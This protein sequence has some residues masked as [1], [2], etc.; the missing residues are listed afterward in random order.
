LRFAKLALLLVPLVLAGCGSQPVPPP[1][2][3]ATPSVGPALGIDLPTDASDNLAELQG[4]RISFVARYYRDPASRWPPLSPTEAQRLSALGLK[5]VTVWEWHSSDPAYFTYATGYNDA[6]S[7]ERQA[8]TVG[9]PPGSAIYFAVDF[10]ARDSALYQVEQYFRGV[11]AG[12]AAAGGGRPEY[13]IGVYGSGAVCATLK[14]A[15]LAQYAWLSGSTAWEGTS[16]YSGWNIRQAAAG[17]KFAHLSFNHDAN[18]AKNDY[19][20]FQLGSYAGNPTGAVVTAV[21]AVPAAAATVVTNAVNSV[22]QPFAASSPLPPAPPASPIVAS[23]IAP[24][25]VAPAP[26]APSPPPVLAAET[27]PTPPPPA[28]ARAAPPPPIS[29]APSAAAAEVAALAAA[30]RAPPPPSHPV[31]EPERQRS[32]PQLAER[33]TTTEESTHGRMT[34]QAAKGTASSKRKSYAVAV[35]NR[36]AA[37]P[38]RHSAGAA[39]EPEQ[40]IS[41]PRRPQERAAHVHAAAAATARSAER[42]APRTVEQR[43]TERPRHVKSS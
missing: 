28:M 3:Q 36:A 22:A 38:L 40:K 9:Q 4:G 33:P 23:P 8:R 21:A 7:A 39:H 34:A 43:R 5:I 13:R 35:N 14:G 31:A 37:V 30:E 12:L 1:I 32:A 15:G 18:E 11:Y 17:A 41:A 6:L 10:N 29:P 2:A 24:S 20:G 16:G 25:P 42:P 19:G 26:V 27:A